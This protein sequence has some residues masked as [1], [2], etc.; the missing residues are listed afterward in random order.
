[1]HPQACT[2]PFPCHQHSFIT[3]TIILLSL[4]HILI[5]LALAGI[6][7]YTMVNARP[8]SD[9]RRLVCSALVVSSTIGINLSA[10]SSVPMAALWI[11]NVLPYKHASA[12]LKKSRSACLCAVTHDESWT[13]DGDKPSYRGNK[14]DQCRS[15]V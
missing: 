9:W 15:S 8:Y 12:S 2:H 3:R 14:G 13:T 4:I 5:D 1:M 7:T 11:R 6:F 10:V